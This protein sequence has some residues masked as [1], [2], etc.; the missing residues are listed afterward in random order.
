IGNVIAGPA[1]SASS[2]GTS[3]GGEGEPDLEYEESPEDSIGNRLDGPPTHESKLGQPAPS[4]RS[5]KKSPRRERKRGQ[6]HLPHGAHPGGAPHKGGE[7]AGQHRAF[8]VGDKVR[9]K[10]VSVGEAG[11]IVD[12]WGKEQAVLDLSEIAPPEGGKDPQ[13][14][15]GVD[16]VV[17]QDG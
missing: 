11:A 14:G 5:H 7:A 6:A 12:L 10:I 15:D 17:M 8:H 1:R 2:E 9:A 4:E 3:D 13:P 16:V